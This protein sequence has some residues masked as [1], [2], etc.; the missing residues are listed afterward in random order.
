MNDYA[1]S[2]SNVDQD[3]KSIHQHH[4]Y[5]NENP[6][7]GLNSFINDV[8]SMAEMNQNQNKEMGHHQNQLFDFGLYGGSISL[9]DIC[10]F[11]KVKKEKS[12]NKNSNSQEEKLKND[13]SSEPQD[14]GGMESNNDESSY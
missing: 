1:G 12:P 9:S 5:Y 8:S 2:M 4:H 10:D 13:E 7:Q 14:K 11:M 3:Y 6:I